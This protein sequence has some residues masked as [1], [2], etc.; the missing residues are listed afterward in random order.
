MVRRYLDINVYDA[1]MQR[2]DFIFREFDNIYVSFSGGKDSGMLLNAVIDF[3]DSRYPGRTVGLYHQDFEAQYTVTTEYIE[4]TFERLKD[5]T[6]PYWVCLPMATRTAMSSYEMFWYPWMTQKG[7]MGTSDAEH[8]YVVNLDAP[9]E[10]YSYKMH[11]E[12]LAKQFGRY[13]ME[14]H[15]GGKT[16][17]PARNPRRRVAQ[18]LFRVS[19]Q[20]ITATRASAG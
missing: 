2:L 9:F 13:Y 7:H 5:R 18:P 1:L 12:D 20:E 15:G 14:K 19:Q 10:H 4:R 6:E 17:W 8:P 3:R 16:V 11:Q